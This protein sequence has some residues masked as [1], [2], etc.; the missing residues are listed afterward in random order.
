MDGADEK[1][2]KQQQGQRQRQQQQQQPQP[3][4]PPP[5]QPQP[6]QQ[7]QPQPQP[8]PQKQKQKQKQPLSPPAS[9][10]TS[11]RKNRAPPRKKTSNQMPKKTC[12]L[13]S[14]NCPKKETIVFQIP[15]IVGFRC[16]W[17]QGGCIHR[18]SW[19]IL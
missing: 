15:T 6:Q 16:C 5:P 17:F 19:A 14:L 10:S 18:M 4:P 12:W 1:P 13:H 2:S 11:P 9:T 7:Q 8:Q 3:Q